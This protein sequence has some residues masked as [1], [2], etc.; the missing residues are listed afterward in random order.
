MLFLELFMQL[1]DKG[2]LLMM[3]HVIQFTWKVVR[4]TQF[5]LEIMWSQ[6]VHALMFFV[7]V[8]S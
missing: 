1:V 3:P 4:T 6:A 2:V 8:W 5:I 7:A